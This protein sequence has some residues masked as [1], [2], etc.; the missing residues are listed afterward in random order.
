MLHQ[1]RFFMTTL[2]HRIYRTV[3][4]VALCGT[5]MAV[6]LLLN[7]LVEGVAPAD[8]IGWGRAVIVDFLRYGER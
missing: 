7:P 1:R 5:F 6:A 2:V 4:V 8:E 3:L